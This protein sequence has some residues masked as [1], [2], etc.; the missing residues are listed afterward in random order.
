MMQ[1]EEVLGDRAHLRKY[2]HIK[3]N[4]VWLKRREKYAII[5]NQILFEKQ[6][7]ILH[8]F[9]SK[10]KGFLHRKLTFDMYYTL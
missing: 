6:N 8:S 7:V 5:S 9:F 4:V 3:F 1:S 2:L 10:L